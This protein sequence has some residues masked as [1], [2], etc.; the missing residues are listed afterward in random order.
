MQRDEAKK[1]LARFDQIVKDDKIPFNDPNKIAS[2]MVSTR[3]SLLFE[4][5]QRN[6]GSALNCIGM[7][8]TLINVKITARAN[9][10][11]SHDVQILLAKADEIYEALK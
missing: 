5:E 6:L 8:I 3:V 9:R 4:G 1:L 10:F 11:S 7:D 2:I